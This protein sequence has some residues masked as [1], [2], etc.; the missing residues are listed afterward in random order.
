MF[1]SYYLK[2]SCSSDEY[3]ALKYFQNIIF[4]ERFHQRCVGFFG[5]CR[6]ELVKDIRVP[7]IGQVLK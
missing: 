6:H 7:L 3:F 1:F 4:S 5:H 2:G